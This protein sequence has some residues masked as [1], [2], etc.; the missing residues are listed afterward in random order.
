MTKPAT[1]RKLTRWLI[2]AASMISAILWNPSL[3][4][5]QT[6]QNEEFG[7]TLSIPKNV[8]LCTPPETEHD[9]GPTLLLDPAYA[10]A[11]HEAERGR[12]V[13]VFAF[14]NAMDDTKTLKKFFQA[15]CN[16]SGKE[17][18]LP[19]P[20][21]LG[22][23]GRRTAVGRVNY[24]NGWVDIVVAT[25]AGKPYAP[26]DPKVPSVNYDL[27]LHTRP[28]NLDEDLRVFRTV[29]QTIQLSPPDP[30]SAEKQKAP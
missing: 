11:C 3:A 20:P 28:E 17:P 9:H 21:H 22:I 27:R 30:P 12:L 2:S 15:W 7:I 24:S 18:C 1:L 10:K 8:T 6:Y 29:L 16:L 13:S 23:P 26:F 5:A 4:V 14:F 19:G 25:Q